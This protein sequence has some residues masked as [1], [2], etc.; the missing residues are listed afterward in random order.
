MQKTQ[1]S[2]DQFNHSL[3]IKVFNLK[4]TTTAAEI[5]MP[6]SSTAGIFKR[7]HDASGVNHM[8][9]KMLSGRKSSTED[10]APD[11]TLFEVEIFQ[12]RCFL[13]ISL[14]LD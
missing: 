8:C 14:N 6:Y 5:D 11:P 10:P 1:N 7:E 4:L 9:D 3:A 13:F 12:I 2:H